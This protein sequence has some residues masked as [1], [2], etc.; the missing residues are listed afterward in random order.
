MLKAVDVLASSECVNG[1]ITVKENVSGLK[2]VL[3][4]FH[5]H[6][7]GGTTNG[8]MN[9]GGT[10]RL[11]TSCWWRWKYNDLNWSGCFFLQLFYCLHSKNILVHTVCIG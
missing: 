7:L 11:E 4:G 6:A 10:R 5:V 8:C 1:L 9:M 3:H 2:P